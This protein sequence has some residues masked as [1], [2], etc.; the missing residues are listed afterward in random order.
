MNL[1]AANPYASGAPR[2]CG[3]RALMVNGAHSV[4]RAATLKTSSEVALQN[5]FEMVERDVMNAS[6]I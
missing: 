1:L 6:S 3:S 2:V 5:T 4:A